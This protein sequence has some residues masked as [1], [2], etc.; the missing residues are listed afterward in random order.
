MEMESAVV[1]V[2]ETQTVEDHDQYPH[3]WLMHMIHCAEIIGY[4]H[5]DITISEW[6]RNYYLAWCNVFHMLPETKELMLQRLR[7]RE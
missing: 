3:H 2:E 4:L 5:S 1:F 6:W 7:E